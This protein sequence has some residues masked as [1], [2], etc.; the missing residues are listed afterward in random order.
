MP[1]TTS[2]R[3]RSPRQLG[4]LA[5]LEELLLGFNHLAGSVPVE[6]GRLASLRTLILTDNAAMSV[7]FRT[8]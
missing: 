6:F 1:N 7:P 8:A 2:W 4:H 5:N 3:P